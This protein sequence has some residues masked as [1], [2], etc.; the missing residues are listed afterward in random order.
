MSQK[1]RAISD[2]LFWIQVVLACV[3][4]VTLF[5]RLLQ[6]TTG[7]SL[8]MH[9]AMLGF[10]LL[11][12]CLAFGAYRATP[13]RINRQTVIIYMLWSVFITCHT[14]AIIWSNDYCWSKNDNITSFMAAMGAVLIFGI[15]LIRGV[16]LNDPMPKGLLAIALKAMPQFMMAFKVAS[17]GGAGI[18]MLVVIV[19]NLT[20]WTRIGQIWFAIREV[21]WSRNLNW[22]LAS[23]TANGISWAAVSLV[24]CSW[25]FTL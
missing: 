11:N 12:L 8:S 1:K 19:G 15:C 18:P 5:I 10:L 23:E 21:G 7:Q 9:V 16:G 3:F 13:N 2:L 4:S 20:I 22:L 25:F 24:W 14:A 6:D 17:V